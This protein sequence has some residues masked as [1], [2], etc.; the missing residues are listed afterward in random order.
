MPLLR[1]LGAALL[2]GLGLSSVHAAPRALQDDNGIC[3]AVASNAVLEGALDG[4]RTRVEG[5]GRYRS[6]LAGRTQP[7]RPNPNI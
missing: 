2:L 4:A 1:S 6:T 5:P 7:K 3:A